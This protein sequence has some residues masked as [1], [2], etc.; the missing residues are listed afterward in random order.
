MCLYLCLK[1]HSPCYKHFLKHLREMSQIHYH[2]HSLSTQIKK[3]K[4]KPR[5]YN[6]I[7]LP[8]HPLNCKAYSCQMEVGKIQLCQAKRWRISRWMALHE[9]SPTFLFTP[10]KKWNDAISE[11]H[12]KAIERWT[13]SKTQQTKVR[14]PSGGRSDRASRRGTGKHPRQHYQ[15]DRGSPSATASLHHHEQNCP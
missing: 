12:H 8:N 10:W 7:F 6:H 3:K 14:N 13:L 9:N 1:I 5:I 2:A 15:W 4:S 11:H